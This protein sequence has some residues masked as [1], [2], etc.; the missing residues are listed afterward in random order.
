M[1]LSMLPAASRDFKLFSK[2]GSCLLHFRKAFRLSP[3]PW[4][5]SNA[6]AVSC[7]SGCAAG[8]HAPIQGSPLTSWLQ[9]N[10]AKHK[11]GRNKNT[12]V[13]LFRTNVSGG[14]FPTGNSLMGCPCNTSQLFDLTH[15]SI[16][17]MCI[18]AL[19]SPQRRICILA[20]H[21]VVCGSHLVCRQI[22]E[23]KSTCSC[24]FGPLSVLQGS[25]LVMQRQPST[26]VGGRHKVVSPHKAPPTGIQ[27][28]ETEGC[29]LIT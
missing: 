2:A 22:M 3:W 14:G 1:L 20:V 4:L 12:M 6:P 27:H 11:K 21:V 25:G 13:E 28:I 5:P 29:S 24:C 19:E 16:Q 23:Q 26:A 8:Q 7:M 18:R 9:I 15:M 10:S 17:Y